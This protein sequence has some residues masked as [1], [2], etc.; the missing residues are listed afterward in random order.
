MKIVQQN[1]PIPCQ[2]YTITCLLA[3]FL[4]FRFASFRKTFAKIFVL[5]YAEISR[6]FSEQVL[7][8]FCENE[9]IY[10]YVS[11]FAILNPVPFSSYRKRQNLTKFKKILSVGL[12][13]QL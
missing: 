3:L 2:E 8:E 10:R 11:I 1:V 13:L 7:G 9:V 4:L 6:S 5:L 12:R